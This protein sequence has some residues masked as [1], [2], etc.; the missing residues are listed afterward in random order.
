MA[1]R[2][3]TTTYALACRRSRGVRVMTGSVVCAELEWA[4]MS[5]TAGAVVAPAAAA[6]A[7]VTAIVTEVA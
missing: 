7:A 4:R 3:G 6:A 1:A 2:R 5:V